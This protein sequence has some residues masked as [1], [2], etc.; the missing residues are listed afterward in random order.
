MR[1]LDEKKPQQRPIYSTPKTLLVSA[2]LALVAGLLASFVAAI[3][4]IFLRLVAGIPTPVELLGDFYLLHINVHVFIGFLNKFAPNPKTAPLGLALLGMLALGTVLGLFYAALAHVRIPTRGYRPGKREWL[5]AA[6]IALAM[7]LVAVILFREVLAQNSYGMPLSWAAIVTVIGL[8][9]VFSAYALTL[10]LA[11][12]G[13]L[14]KQPDPS[15]APGLQGRR[16]LISGAG[17]AALTVGAGAGTLG[18][19]KAYYDSYTAYDGKETP[20]HDSRTQQI[21]PNSEFYQVTQNAIDPHPA[22]GLWRLEVRGLVGKTG[23]Y[24]YDEIQ[25]LPSTSRAITM[26]CISNGVGGHLMSTA[27]G[28]A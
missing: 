15:T 19:V 27:S 10:C 22:A 20:L 7:T 1:T 16:Q 5:T 17:I 28:R 2:L 24:T 13:L 4:M 26:E 14:P 12:R 25:Q 8:L 18:M 23:D 3:V 9:I 6:A 21:T 11:Y